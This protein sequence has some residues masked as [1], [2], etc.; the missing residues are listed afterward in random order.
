MVDIL[1]RVGIADAA[2]QRVYEALATAEGVASWWSTKSEG[3]SS[4]GDI[5]KFWFEKAQGSIDVKVL[6]LVP[7]E[8]VVWEVV[9]GPEE[10]L[11]TTVSFDLSVDGNYT[12]VL[13]AHR[14]WAEPVEFMH[15]CT[16]KWGVFLLSL[17]ELLETGRGRP[18]PHDVKIDN[19]N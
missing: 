1:H 14:G 19:W 17:K 10:W 15:H 7:N 2:P 8:R 6:E 9:G 4:V 3:G 13:F 11:G 16:T 12:V 18:E 5:Q